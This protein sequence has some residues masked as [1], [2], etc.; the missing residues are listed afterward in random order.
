MKTLFYFN[1]SSKLSFKVGFQNRLSSTKPFSSPLCLKTK[2]KCLFSTSKNS[3]GL[4]SYFSFFEEDLEPKDL[5][6][7][8]SEFLKDIRKRLDKQNLFHK[9]QELEKQINVNRI[10]FKTL[11]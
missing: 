4:D 1:S 10:N 2:Q 5:E 7:N 8:A 11:M 3:Q 9:F 6:K